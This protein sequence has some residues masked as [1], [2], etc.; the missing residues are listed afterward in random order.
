MLEN[1]NWET[2]EPTGKDTDEPIDFQAPLDLGITLRG[3]TSP[4]NPEEAVGV[5]W[6]IYDGGDYIS[7]RLLEPKSGVPGFEYI[8]TP[9]PDTRAE[10]TAEN[11]IVI[12]EALVSDPGSPESKADSYYFKIQIPPDPSPQN[13]P[14][15]GS[16][17]YRFVIPPG[18]QPTSYS[19]TLQ[20]IADGG[21]QTVSGSFV[22][23]GDDD[24]F[25]RDYVP[26]FDSAPESLL[27]GPYWVRAEIS[28]SDGP[29]KTV[30]SLDASDPDAQRVWAYANWMWEGSNGD[31]SWAVF[32]IPEP[33]PPAPG[34]IEYN[35]GDTGPAGGLIFFVRTPPD[36]ESENP[37]LSWRY[38]EAAPATWHAS[39]NRDPS[40]VFNVPNGPQVFT[41]FAS[42]GGGRINTTAIRNQLETGDASNVTA[43][44]AARAADEARVSN[45]GTVYDDWFLPTRDE[46]TRFWEAS[47]DFPATADVSGGWYWTSS[48]S[49][50]RTRAVATSM[51]NGRRYVIDQDTTTFV[52]RVRP[53]RRF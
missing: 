16:I 42:V 41:A 26:S 43:I 25:Y 45:E 21:Q 33:E 53:I 11:R 23:I 38:L 22:D 9:L 17:R 6:N 39:G 40:F 10:G 5:E 2:Y 15:H 30:G 14:T 46:L 29:T 18:L 44:H 19:I 7:L 3:L 1:G 47:V 4:Q 35:I 48:A 28:F 51:L 20:P 12:L 32:E 50:D 49:N 37:E 34:E 31:S 13:L 24:S 52:P 27:F 36:A 8:A